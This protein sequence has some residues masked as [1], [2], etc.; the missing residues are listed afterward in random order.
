MAGY[1]FANIVLNLLPTRFLHC[2]HNTLDFWRSTSSTLWARSSTGGTHR[3]FG[4]I[5]STNNSLRL[6]GITRLKPWLRDWHACRRPLK[7]A[8]FGRPNH[9]STICQIWLK[10]F[11]GLSTQALY[12]T[13]TLQKQSLL[14]CNP[15]R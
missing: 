7:A 13:A 14:R 4:I 11:E 3:S 10:P 5:T 9:R 1:P 2:Y 6:D 12:F 8:A 15:S